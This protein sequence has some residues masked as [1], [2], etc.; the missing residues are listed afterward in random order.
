MAEIFS[1]SNLMDKTNSQRN[2]WWNMRL[3]KLAEL[4]QLQNEELYALNTSMVKASQADLYKDQKTKQSQT[5]A[6]TYVL[7]KY[8]GSNLQESFENLANPKRLWGEDNPA[9]RAKWWNTSAN[10]TFQK[11]PRW[12]PATIDPSN[13]IQAL[14]ISQGIAPEG[15]KFASDGVTLLQKNPNWNI[16]KGLSNFGN[17]LAGS[18]YATA[19]TGLSP[20]ASGVGVVGAVTS[21]LADDKDPTTFTSNEAAGAAMSWGATAFQVAMMIPGAGPI[22]AIP[23]AIAAGLI[24]SKKGK[25]QA[26]EAKRA[27]D[28]RKKIW[29]EKILA[30]N[31][32]QRKAITMQGN[33]PVQ[34]N[35]WNTNYS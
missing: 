16:G 15:M 2:M 6:Q 20:M 19:V 25:K 7:D 21:H 4:N 32:K 26:E 11:T 28:K 14:K 30:F 9:N 3:E 34:F 33:V 5:T 24:A 22:L 29:D 10:S 23:A 12:V 35:W 13:P 8:K 17:Y 27:E 1:Y 18:K 31:R